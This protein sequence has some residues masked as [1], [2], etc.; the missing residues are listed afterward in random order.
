MVHF[1]GIK[2]SGMASLACILNDLG[3][4]VTGSDIEKYIF[5]QQPLE[6]R[7]I[8]I[9][10][11]DADNIQ[12]GMNVIIGN[13]FDESNCEVAKAL[14]T[15]GVNS[16]YYHEYLGQLVERYTTISVAGTHGKTTTTGMLSHMMSALNKTGYLIGDGTGEMPKDSHYFALESCEYQRHFMAYHPDY[17]IITNIDL[18]HIDYYKDLEDYKSAFEAFANQVKK[19]VVVCGDDENIRSLSIK[20]PILTYGFNDCDDVQA[21]NFEEDEHGMRFDLYYH[22]KF[23]HHFE[24]PYVGRHLLLNSLAVIAIALLEGA[25]GDLIQSQMSSFGGVKRRFNIEENGQYVYVDDYAHHPTAIKAT[26]EAA[27]VRFP[28]KKIIAIFKPDRYSRI[29]AFMDDFAKSL[30][31][32]DEVVLCPFPENAKHEEGINITI[33]DLQKLIPNAEVM[34]ENEA[35]AKRLAAYGEAV[36][37]FM[38][39]KDIYKFKNIVKSFH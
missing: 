12:P 21:V 34:V 39:S 15:E 27:R 38:S 30:S 2:G 5:T 36:Y 37:L 33:E 3:E 35:N 20:T 23:F 31:S 32:A 25:D 18:D 19:A 17:A 7:K 9:T 4:T 6:A 13:A 10:P 29:Y 1:I 11:F 8:K 14:H 16:Y 26:I 24:L 28:G 22:H